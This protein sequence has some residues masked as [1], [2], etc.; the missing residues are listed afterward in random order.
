MIHCTTKLS[1]VYKYRLMK[2]KLQSL[3]ISVRCQKVQRLEALLAH[4]QTEP[5]VLLGCNSMTL[6]VRPKKTRQ[7]KL[8]YVGQPHDV[9]F[10][11]D[12]QGEMAD[13][14]LNGGQFMMDVLK[15]NN[16]A[17]KVSVHEVIERMAEKANQMGDR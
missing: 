14:G 15:Y 17:Q 11:Q 7:G 13:M 8:F 10:D 2:K 6:C 16:K 3:G 1:E 9:Q 12:E 5:S 4:L